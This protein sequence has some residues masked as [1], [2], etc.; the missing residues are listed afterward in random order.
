MSLSKPEVKSLLEEH[1]NKGVTK[2]YYEVQSISAVN[3]LIGSRFD[4]AFKIFYLEMLNKDLSFAD[5]VYKEHIR[6][7]SLGRFVEHGN[8]N[9]NSIDKFYSSF[10]KTFESIKNNGFDEKKTLI[11]LSKN[12]VILNGAHR[13]A[14]AIILDENV[15]CVTLGLPCLTYDYKY[16]YDRN[17]SIDI[18]D[19]A[20][21]TFV[22]YAKNIYIALVW[23]VSE[24]HKQEV[25]HLIPNIV[26]KK[27]VSLNYNGAHNLLSQ[28]YIEEQWIGNVENRFKGVERKLVKCFSYK[29]NVKVIAFQEESIEEVL[30]IK[31]NIR[32]IFNIG[33]HSIHITDTKKE[34]V[35]LSEILF[36]ENSIHFLNYAKPNNFISFH[37]EMTKAKNSVLMN[38][39]NKSNVVFNDDF[40]LAA[41]GIRSINKHKLLIGLYTEKIN[42]SYLY[43]SDLF[44]EEKD[45]D[46]VFD[47]SYY[48]YF[49]GVKFK[50]FKSVLRSKINSSKESDLSDVLLMNRYVKSNDE[51]RYLTLIKQ[52]LSY[53]V[54]ILKS[55]TVKVLKIFHLYDSVSYFYKILRR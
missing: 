43:S 19:I 38:K 53:K 22:K 1:L 14:S 49:N 35:K 54:I 20:A 4:L 46:Y 44:Y 10:E 13:V 8:N 26:Y 27:N 47:P 24:G 17:V 33:K 2:D 39:I 41:Y 32:D 21:T 28:V 31:K 5:K 16:F 11:P 29:D 50:S 51:K 6:A 52:W 48:F 23:P 55:K 18:L 42:R 25:E 37:S 40:V 7:F 30:R 45:V 9:K 15:S 36:N 3:L 34:A 12:G